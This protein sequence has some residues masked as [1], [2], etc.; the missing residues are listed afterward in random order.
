MQGP[1]INWVPVPTLVVEPDDDEP[2]EPDDDVPELALLAPDEAPEVLPL[3]EPVGAGPV[4]PRAT[5]ALSLGTL[6]PC[7]HPPSRSCATMAP[8]HLPE[9]NPQQPE[10]QSASLLHGPV[11]NWAALPLPAPLVVVDP[12]LPAPE[13]E[14]V[15]LDE[16]VFALDAP[17]DEPLEDPVGAGPV[18]PR[19]TAALSL[20]EVLPWPQPPSRS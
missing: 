20:G 12:P 7:P 11:M 5:A 2:P 15:E 18:K 1:V 6:L 14:E 17:L 13:D 19:A 9:L 4:N 8:A 10:A 3:D 16:L